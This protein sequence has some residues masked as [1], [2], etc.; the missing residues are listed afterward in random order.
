MELTEELIL[1][2]GERVKAVIADGSSLAQINHSLP[3]NRYYRS[4]N[5]MYRMAGVYV[6][7]DDLEA[8]LKLYIRFSR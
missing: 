3:L 7:D 2:P 4:L 5:E 6:H 8:A 1:D